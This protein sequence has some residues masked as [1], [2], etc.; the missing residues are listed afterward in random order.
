MRNVKHIVV[1]CTAGPQN[2]STQ[3]IL[4]FWRNELRWRNVGYHVLIDADGTATV[5]A[6]PDRV[7][8]GVAG[9]NSTSYHIAYK[10]GQHGIDNRTEAQKKALR[11]AIMKAKK[12]WP[13]A[14]IVGHRDLS[15]DLNQDGIIS[16]NEWT[17]LCPGFDARKEYQNL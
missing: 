3:S 8:N 13:K 17:K 16:P 6:T 10:G 11:A 2:Q 7:T 1:H 5:L 14:R 9:Q 12:L 15:P 4:N